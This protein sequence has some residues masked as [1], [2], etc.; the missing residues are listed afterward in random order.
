M[1]ANK[2]PDSLKHRGFLSNY[3]LPGSMIDV[4]KEFESISML[5]SPYGKIKTLQNQSKGYVTRRLI[6]Q[7]IYKNTTNTLIMKKIEDFMRKE[8]I[9]IN[10][11][12][13]KA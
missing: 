10:K 9:R 7:Y 12:L 6:L 8:D 11:L 5:K 3:Y 1:A 13:S 4:A 2:K